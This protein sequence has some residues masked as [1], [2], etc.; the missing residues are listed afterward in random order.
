MDNPHISGTLDMLYNRGQAFAHAC[1]LL[2]CKEMQ[3]RAVPAGK[4]KPI[5]RER[6]AVKI[7]AQI[8]L[9]APAE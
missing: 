6:G 7:Y 8:Y 5:S 9:Q 1:P 2:S 4:A 3:P